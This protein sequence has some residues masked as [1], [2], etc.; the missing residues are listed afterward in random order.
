MDPA[1]SLLAS[2]ALALLFANSAYHKLRDLERFEA[3]VADYRLLPS[4][5]AATATRAL[6][7]VEIGLAAALVFPPTARAGSLFAATLLSVYSLAIGI[8]LA[9]GRRD[10]DCGCGGD[11]RQPL[12]PGLLARNALLIVIAIGGAASIPSGA[13]ALSPFD[14]ITVVFG[15]A[16][17]ALAWQAAGQLHA[18][19][20]PSSESE[21]R[22][23]R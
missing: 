6:P 10:F 5:V 15:L 3:I 20:I 13:R 23:L 7:L 14:G 12:G 21:R 4:V 16:T 19:L 18:N 17:L 1:Y 8:N 22:I 9:R 11:S 2:L